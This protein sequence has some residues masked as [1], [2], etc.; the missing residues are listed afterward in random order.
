M[1]KQGEMLIIWLY[2]FR[3]IRTDGS[4]EHYG[5]TLAVHFSYPNTSGYHR[6][7]SRSKCHCAT[8]DYAFEDLEM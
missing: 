1:Q 6:T 2:T 7:S 5:L 8:P 3:C 4:V